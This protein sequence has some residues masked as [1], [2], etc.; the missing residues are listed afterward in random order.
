MITVD[1]QTRAYDDAT[2]VRREFG[3]VVVS[4]SVSAA[5]SSISTA[6]KLARATLAYEQ[7]IMGRSVQVVSHD[8]R[9]VTYIPGQKADLR[10]FIRALEQQLIEEGAATVSTF[11]SRGRARTVTW[12]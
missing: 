12:S 5:Q 11:G 1:G 3:P 8:G 10:K 9:T 7:L 6:D 2:W 4:M